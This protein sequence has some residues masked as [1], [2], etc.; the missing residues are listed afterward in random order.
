MKQL[1]LDMFGLKTLARLPGHN[2]YA[3][4]GTYEGSTPPTR[5][6]VLRHLSELDNPFG[7]RA[8]QV[9]QREDGGIW[10]IVI[11]TD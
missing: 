11:H 8:F 5:E 4:Q 7:S 6:D 9:L 1:D 10:S 2:N 3:A